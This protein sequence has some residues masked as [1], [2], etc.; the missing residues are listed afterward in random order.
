M[1]DLQSPKPSA[2]SGDYRSL[3]KYLENRFAD[4]VFLTFEQ[5]E[6][7]L[8]FALPDLARLRQEWWSNTKDGGPHSSS[9]LRANRIATANLHAQSVMFERRAS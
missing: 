3:F 8:G 5:I 7:L 4:Q 9:W 2:D 1:A 6:G